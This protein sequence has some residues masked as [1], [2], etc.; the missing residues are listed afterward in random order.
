MAEIE[1]EIKISVQDYNWICNK[2]AKQSWA[3]FRFPFWDESE[4]IWFVSL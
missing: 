3:W 2:T 4:S 1:T